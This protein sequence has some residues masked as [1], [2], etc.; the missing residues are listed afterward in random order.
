VADDGAAV[1]AIEQCKAAG[2]GHELSE[3]RDVELLPE[4]EVGV[5][6]DAAAGF[7]DEDSSHGFFFGIEGGPFDDGLGERIPPE[8]DPQHAQG[9]TLELPI[10]ADTGGVDEAALVGDELA[11]AHA[12]EAE[13]VAGGAGERGAKPLF[14]GVTG[15]DGV[16]ELRAAVGDDSAF[17][18]AEDDIEVDGVGIENLA[19]TLRDV[20]E[21]G[22]GGG[23]A[24]GDDTGIGGPPADV[25]GSLVEVAVDQ[26]DV[27]EG[28]AGEAITEDGGGEG[29]VD[30][31]KF[32]NCLVRFFRERGGDVGGLFGDFL[33][34]LGDDA[35]GSAGEAAGA[36]RL[37][38]GV[39][40]DELRFA[41][42]IA[43]PVDGLRKTLVEIGGELRDSRRGRMFIARGGAEFRIDSNHICTV[44]GP[45]RDR[46]GWS[47]AS[48]P[49]IRSEGKARQVD[50]RIVQI[51]QGRC[52]A[53]L[54]PGRTGGVAGN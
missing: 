48:R 39:D 24:G 17:E 15:A 26:V 37:H 42:E 41:V 8:D 32:D 43:N 21:R 54:V 3:G 4:A 45:W 46:G 11:G 49:L 29:L 50:P 2:I 22:L 7:E 40:G 16:E 51:V 28:E 6:E 10:L 1:G 44:T 13:L 14:V 23:G 19:E 47:S 18:I 31:A 20:L 38:F 27:G 33:D 9:L 53:E 25:A 30:L 12:A 34:G 35:K 5:G 52:L 36:H